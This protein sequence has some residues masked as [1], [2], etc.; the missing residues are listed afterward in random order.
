DYG[1]VIAAMVMVSLFS[2]AGDFGITATTARMMAQDPARRERLASCALWTWTG[3]SLAAAV[4]VLVISTVAY[5][6]ADRE[7]TR[8]AVWIIL[9]CSTALA[10][11]FGVANATA[12]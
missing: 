1:Q 7:L 11:I 3:F 8:H 12:I 4:T 2:M 9:F 10:P 6:G 5:G